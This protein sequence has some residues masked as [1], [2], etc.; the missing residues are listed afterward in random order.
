VLVFVLDDRPTPTFEFLLEPGRI[1]AVGGGWLLTH[2]KWVGLGASGGSIGQDRVVATVRRNA[3]WLLGR[4]G[5]DLGVLYPDARE[6]VRG[7]AAVLYRVLDFALV[8][9]ALRDA[10]LAGRDDP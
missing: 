4:D 5:I 3:P 2:L 8:R 10:H 6:P 9:Q 1:H 7:I